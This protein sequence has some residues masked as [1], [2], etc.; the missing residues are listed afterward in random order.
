MS[1]YEI[2]RKNSGQPA[3]VKQYGI[4][5][6]K[7]FVF[8]PMKMTHFSCLIKNVLKSTCTRTSI[9]LTWITKSVKR[10]C[11]ILFYT[12]SIGYFRLPRKSV[13]S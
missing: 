6:F 7:N 13:E 4:V 3:T 10:T 11:Q 2:F 9:P 8:V 12:L 1:D 5:N